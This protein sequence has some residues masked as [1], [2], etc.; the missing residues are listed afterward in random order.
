MSR[1]AASP[2]SCMP[3]HLPCQLRV[4][5]V[6]VVPHRQLVVLRAGGEHAQHLTGGRHMH[7]QQ[8]EGTRRRSRVRHVVTQMVGSVGYNE[9]WIV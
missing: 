5:H 2:S 1:R 3:A 9:V 8:Q 4:E 6:L 7:A